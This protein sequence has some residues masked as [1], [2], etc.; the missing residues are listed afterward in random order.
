M[1]KKRGIKVEVHK[2]TKAIVHCFNNGGKLLI[3]G[4]GGSAAEADHMAAEL[5]GTFE[6]K[7]RKAL[8]AYPLS[9]NGAIISS[10]ANDQ[11]FKYVFSRQVEAYGNVDDLLMIITTSDARGS[12]SDNL[13]QAAKSAKKAGM[14]VI[15]LVSSKKTKRLLKHIDYPVLAE[16]ESTAEIQENQIAIVHRISCIIESYF[17]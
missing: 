12:H 15:G 3:C 1:G 16:G 13:L 9:T 17:K 2:A 11:G 5:V 10:L 14:K 8:P 6:L 7:N 4:N